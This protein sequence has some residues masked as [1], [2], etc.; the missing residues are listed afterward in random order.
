MKIISF[1]FRTSPR[2]VGLAIVAGIVSGGCSTVLLGLISVAT[3]NLQAVTSLQ[4]KL[5]VALCIAAPIMRFLSESL[6]MRIGQEAIF[7][8]RV[9]LSRRILAAP[10]RQLE[11]IGAH[12]LM[13]A[14]TDDVVSISTAVLIIPLAAINLA[15]V[16]GCLIY[17][18][19]LSTSM[20]LVVLG[21]MLV[22]VLS[23]QIPVVRAVRR[24][25]RARDAEDGLYK[26]FRAV[27]DG[28]KELKLHRKRREAFLNTSL[29]GNASVYRH[30]NT[31]G[32]AIFIA[33]TCW[34]QTLFFVVIGL[35]LF[36]VPSFATTS[37]HQLVGFVV[38]V[39]YMMTPLQVTLNGLPS[40]GRAEVAIKK[41]RDLGFELESEP[42]REEAVA[43]VEGE[44]AWNALEFDG[45]THTYVN[46]DDGQFRLGPV[47]MTLRR[48][49]LVFLTGGNGSGK[50]TLA[51][52]LLGLY[53]PEA[54]SIRLDGRQ[55]TEADRDDYRQLFSAVY[56]D[57]YLFERMLG[58]ESPQLDDEAQ[59]YLAQLHLTGKVEIKDNVLS[60]TDLSQGQRKRLALLT[61]YL[62]NRPIYLFDEWAADQDPVFKE[63]F[64]YQLLPDLK[65]RGKTVIV[66]SHDDRYFHVA[67][68]V[69]KL[70][71]GQI[72]SDEPAFYTELTP[73]AETQSA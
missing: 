52:L 22:G 15:V 57:F 69:I 4:V 5:F 10:L 9:Q 33:A 68:R 1:L 73:V 49:E 66:I 65:C 25:R 43:S 7:E 21:F 6:L 18:G 17:L 37:T 29:A 40:L 12:R 20:L 46:G 48:G 63:L 11:Q 27:T 70:E 13:A 53:T 3:G 23:Y 36:V 26:D 51:K 42:Q 38:V 61:A 19:W 71:D 2:S 58:L 56:S 24:M 44:I 72:A 62:E 31:I 64:Y 14:L 59:R 47:R 41:L 54:G 8:Q 35:L 34:G 39:L 55:I 50:T 32:Q 28:V 30:Q 60:T 16:L 45:I 67:D